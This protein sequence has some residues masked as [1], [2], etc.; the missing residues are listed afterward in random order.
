M[1]RQWLAQKRQLRAEALAKKKLAQR[2][3][4][5]QE[6]EMVSWAGV[7]CAVAVIAHLPSSRVPLG[8]LPTA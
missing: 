3:R 4:A 7:C 1:Y 5:K 8:S 6:Q 2:A